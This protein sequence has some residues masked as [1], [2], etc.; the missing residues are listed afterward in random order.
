MIGALRR[1][2]R[3]LV[4]G[5]PKAKPLPKPKPA[6]YSV[7]RQRRVKAVNGSASALDKGTVIVPPVRLYGRV[8]A[9]KGCTI[10]KYTYIGDGSYLNGTDVG[11]YC[12]IARDVEIGLAQHPLAMLSAHP[13]QYN[14]KHFGGVAGYETTRIPNPVKMRRT[15]IGNDVWIGAKVVIPNGLTIGHGAVIGAGA[16]VT[17]DVPPYAIVGGVPARLI[18]YRFD[19]ALIARLLA[20]QW[21]VLDPAD[22]DGVDFADVPAALDEIERRKSA[23]RSTAQA[24]LA[25][26]LVNEVANG[27]KGLLWFDVPKSYV[28]PDL[29]KSAG[30]VTVLSGGGAVSEGDYAI[31]EARFHAPG[32][33]FAVRLA[34]VEADLPRGSVR[35][36]LAFPE[37]AATAAP[38]DAAVV[39]DGSRASDRREVNAAE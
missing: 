38:P 31:A 16:V 12:C 36:R 7:N 8:R 1:F 22:L 30:G 11:N 37:A 14:D 23:F 15:T 34:G 33:R 35:F 28:D 26:E 29:L 6:P 24:A 10:G 17:K 20:S 4:R 18:R 5:R 3:R 9:S 32:N 2:L 39:N 19:K 25:E 27:S 13:F 21:W